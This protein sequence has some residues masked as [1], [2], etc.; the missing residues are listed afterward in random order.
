MRIKDEPLLLR[1]AGES[2]EYGV[3]V[4]VAGS[5]EVSVMAAPSCPL[6]PATA[7]AAAPATART[8]TK[9]RRRPP[10]GAALGICLVTLGNPI[11][12]PQSG[13]RLAWC[14][15]RRD[16]HPVAQ[17]PLGPSVTV[18]AAVAAFSGA[19]SGAVSAVAPAWPTATA[20]LGLLAG[21]YAVASAPAGPGARLVGAVGL[22][23][24]PWVI[25]MLYALAT[26]MGVPAGVERALFAPQLR[27]LRTTLGLALPVLAVTVLLG[28]HA[29]GWPWLRALGVL[30]ALAVACVPLLLPR[31]R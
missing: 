27:R 1:P 14:M 7:K 18:L 2:I 30:A 13:T 25:H 6:S 29:P 31:R 23:A 19:V 21:A 8:A 16:L 22:G 12:L 4:G 15:P 26:A 9:A 3:R 20:T 10:T 28:E 11:R 24:V 17:P 5:R